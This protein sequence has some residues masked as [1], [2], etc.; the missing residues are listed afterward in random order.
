MHPAGD[1]DRSA[2]TRPDSESAACACAVAVRH[3]AAGQA[4]LAGSRARVPCSLDGLRCWCEVARAPGCDHPL[5]EDEERVSPSQPTAALAGRW[6][7]LAS[8]HGA[9]VGRRSLST[10]LATR[11]PERVQTQTQARARAHTRTHARA[12]ARAHAHAHTHMHTHTH[13]H[14]QSYA[15]RHTHRT[16]WRA[17]PLWM[18]LYRVQARCFDRFRPLLSAVAPLGALRVCERASVWDTVCEIVL[19][20]DIITSSQYI[21]VAPPPVVR[22]LLEAYPLAI[23]VPFSVP[24]CPGVQAG[25]LLGTHR[26]ETIGCPIPP[27]LWAST[28]VCARSD[29][30]VTSTP[31]GLACLTDAT[32]ACGRRARR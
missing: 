20:N 9:A 14:T 7:V 2:S 1:G 22:A 19:Q 18:L 26:S 6:S 15:Q 16:G 24:V 12:R 25:A 31:R 11:V 4:P 32:V 3:G 5:S 28:S 21:D 30:T 13:T 8:A 17:K 29:L 23:W 27:L 10:A